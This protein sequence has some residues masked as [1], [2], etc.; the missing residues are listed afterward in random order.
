MTEKFIPEHIDPLRYAEQSLRL[1]GLIKLSD[2]H[3]L[4][5]SLSKTDDMVTV[6]LQF[7]LDEQGKPY[8]KGHLQTILTLQ[9]QRCMGPFSYE[10]IA[11]FV[12][13]IVNTLEEAKALPELYE[14]AMTKEG[15]LALRELVEDEIILN[16]PIIPKHE[17]EDCSVNIPTIE[18]GWEQ[19]KRENPFQ[20]LESLKRKSDK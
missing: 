11:D 1:D 17:P 8:I 13:G 20:V 9:C 5:T 3:R 18:S 10:I 2:M 15:S 12:L 19:G 14:P 16:L 6:S 4:S 7:G